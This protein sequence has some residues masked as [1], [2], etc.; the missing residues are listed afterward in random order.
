MSPA[1]VPKHKIKITL[2]YLNTIGHQDLID[3]NHTAP[4]VE[5]ID[6]K[7]RT[8][9]K[10]NPFTK[11]PRFQQIIRGGCQKQRGLKH[12]ESLFYILHC[13]ITCESRW[14]VDREDSDLEEKSLSDC[15]SKGKV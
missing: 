15:Q 13:R 5:T 11:A 4:K 12:V 3:Q 2:V 10:L 1:G 14:V 8:R 6:T 7:K 9:E